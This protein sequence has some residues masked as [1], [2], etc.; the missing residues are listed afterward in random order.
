MT[1]RKHLWQASRVYA[2]EFPR[3]GSDDGTIQARRASRG[4]FVAGLTAAA[5]GEMPGYYSVYAFPWGHPKNDSIPKVDCIFIDLDVTNKHYQPNPNKAGYSI[6]FEDWRRDMSALLARARMIATALI[7]DG[8]AQHFRVVLSGHKG[9]HLYLD[10]PFIAP[11]NGTYQQFKNGLKAYGE[12]VVDWL[13]HLAGG[14][15][16]LPWVDVDASDLA[17]LARHPNT[18]HHGAAYDDTERWC[19][20]V[21]VE[22]L[23]TLTVDDYLDLTASPRPMTPEMGREPSERAGNQATQKVRAAIDSPDRATGTSEYNPQVL[24]QY[25]ERA[26]DAI[27]LEDLLDPLIMGNKPC[28]QAFRE[29]ADAYEHGQESRAMELSIMGHFIDHEV[30]IDVMHEFFAAIPGYDEDYTQDLLED[31][32]GRGYKPFNC[33]NIAGGYDANGRAVTGRAERF[34]LG[35][36]CKVYTRNDDIHIH[37]KTH[38]DA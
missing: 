30:P 34:C 24:K 8:S 35:Q 3:R 13:D 23:S 14:V 20:P 2:P 29:R 26:N 21:T 38:P 31:L 37:D 15:N 22:E 5:S 16:I 33:E 36:D 17:R 10:F 18:V 7:E 9:V 4:D 12:D 1:W 28:I 11:E 32:I 19:V 25:R 6:D 27:E